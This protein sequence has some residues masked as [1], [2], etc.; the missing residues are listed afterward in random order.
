[1]N[2]S[3]SENATISSNFLLDLLALH[4]QDRAVQVDVL[5]A[6]QLR[7][8][9]GA[10]LQQ[11]PT[12]PVMSARPVVGSVIRDRIFSSVLLPAPFRPMIPTTSP[13]FTSKDTSFSAQ[14]ES[15]TTSFPFEFFLARIRSPR[16]GALIPSVNVSPKV[17]YR[18]F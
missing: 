18:A 4:A 1:M 13:G 9:A 12:R 2:F 10:H 17:L 16:S 3:T 5:P 15:S 11:R 8:E 14:I 7:M 6:R